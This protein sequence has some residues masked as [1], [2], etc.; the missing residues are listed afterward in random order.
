MGSAGI[1]RHIL[2][3]TWLAVK[4]HGSVSQASAKTGISRSTVQ[5]RYKRALEAGFQDVVSSDRALTAKYG[6]KLNATKTLGIIPPDIPSEDED[7]D[8]VMNRLAESIKR[9]KAADDAKDWM[10]F[11]VEGEGPF[12]LVFV[13][14][15]HGDDC[16]IDKL[17]SDVELIK[18]TQRMWAVGLGDYINQ[19]NKKLFHKYASQ[20]INERDAY[21]IAQWLFKQEIWMLIILG[22]HDGPRW[23]GNG[24]PLNFMQHSAPV[25]LQNWQAKFEIKAGLNSWRI[26][27]AHDFPGNS[28]WNPLH[29]PG[30]RAQLTGAMA[31]LF[32]CGDHHVFGLSQTQHEH[33][34]RPY[35]VGRA[36]GYK[37]LDEFALEKGYG[38]QTMGHSIVGVFD[39]D[40]VMTCFSDIE[41]AA[42][43]LNWLRANHEE[44]TKAPKSSGIGKRSGKAKARSRIRK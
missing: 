2:E 19:W 22:N 3:E 38:G 9:R 1:A 15:P 24:S 5:N 4:K 40:G 27:A 43:Y 17:R 11:K 7:L 18:N 28:I 36:K 29:G 20:T 44:K 30:R 23:H 16:D 42:S 8:A 26:W 13:G 14:D 6:S 41:K 10:K 21:R 37:M 33:T 39:T 35:W 25:E 31:D 32:I 34:H 12:A